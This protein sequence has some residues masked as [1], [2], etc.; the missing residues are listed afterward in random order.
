MQPP[1]NSMQGLLSEVER[2]G[3][4]GTLDT[5]SLPDQPQQ[6]PFVAGSHAWRLKIPQEM[7]GD[8]V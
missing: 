3:Q 2:L 1:D 6:I 7:D 4:I 5:G 8:M